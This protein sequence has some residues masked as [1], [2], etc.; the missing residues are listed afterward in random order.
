[1]SYIGN[2]PFNASF[3][4]DTFSGTGSAT[5]FTMQIAPA[6]VNSLFVI[7]SGVVQ[8]PATYGVVGNTLTFSQAPPAG[9]NNIVCRY[10]ALPASNVTTSAYRSYSEFIATVGQTTFNAGSYSPGFVDVYRNGVKLNNSS[11]TAT[12]GTTV[13]LAN[14][15]ATGDSV[16]VIGFYISSVLNAIPNVSGSITSSN[17]DASGGA[18]TGAMIIP[19]GPTSQRPASPTNGMIR[20]NTTTGYVEYWDPTTTNWISIGAFAASGGTVTNYNSGGTNYQVHTFLSSSAFVVSAGVKTVDY[21]IV[22]GGG[23]GGGNPYHGGGGGAGGFLTGSTTI[24]VGSYQ[25]TV[26]S[27]GSGYASGLTG[28]NGTNS[29]FNNLTAIGGGGGGF[30]SGDGPGTAGGS[31]G[32]ST[33]RIASVASGT[34][35]Q[36]NAGGAGAPA[37]EG[38]N[39]GAGGGGGSSS[40]GGNG[41]TT[42][43]GNGGS[44]TNNSLRTGSAVAYAGGGGGSTYGGGTPGSGSAGGGAGIYGSGG[45]NG[46]DNT[47]SGG[48]GRDG[49]GPGNIGSGNG[50][51]GIVVIRYTV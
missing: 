6:G 1:M 5:A 26:G 16:V 46:G 4:V 12:N 19:T 48:G 9:T 28:R 10:L 47:G 37:P 14:A 43:G 11:F 51:S 27:G 20:K 13:V 21:L 30:D 41:T 7:V 25:I 49:R 44:G 29:S 17:L 32:G 23:G 22:A 15:A 24:A 3:L 33:V 50:G 42:T 36:G 40:V 18:G 45:G 31:G 35:G 38:P 34:A 39:Y 2:Q 8:S